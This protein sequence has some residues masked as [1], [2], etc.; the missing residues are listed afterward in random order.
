LPGNFYWVEPEREQKHGGDLYLPLLVGPFSNKDRLFGGRKE[1]SE[2]KLLLFISFRFPW[3]PIPEP[4]LNPRS[5]LIP[6]ER[7]LKNIPGEHLLVHPQDDE[8]IKGN[9]PCR[10]RIENLNSCLPSGRNGKII[11]ERP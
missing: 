2:E 11:K 1:K 8:T 6:Q 5:N 3:D 9:P 7:I 4:K 10:H